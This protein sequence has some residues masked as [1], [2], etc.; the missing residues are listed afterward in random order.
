MSIDRDALTVARNAYKEISEDVSTFAL[1]TAIQT[2]LNFS[3]LEEQRDKAQ[4]RNLA[5]AKVFNGIQS[6]LQDKIITGDPEASKILGFVAVEIA[7][8]DEEEESIILAQLANNYRHEHW[9]NIAESLIVEQLNEIEK[10]KE[11]L[12]NKLT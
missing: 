9:L 6:Y 11:Q 1:Q 5:W 2:Y 4:A 8:L 10:L 3:R 7:R 12:E